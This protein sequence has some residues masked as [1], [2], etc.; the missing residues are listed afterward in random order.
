MSQVCFFFSSRRRHTRYWRDWSSDVCSSDLVAELQA[1][2]FAVQQEQAPKESF[3]I[4]LRKLFF[5]FQ[6][7]DYPLSHMIASKDL[8]LLTFL[9]SDA[10]LTK[11]VFDLVAL[12]VLGFI[13]AVDFTDTQ[14]FIQKIGFPIVFEI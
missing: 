6:D 7:T 1:L 10:T 3:A 2:G 9:T 14:D 12:Q 11:E 8:D 4:F 5:H 13:P